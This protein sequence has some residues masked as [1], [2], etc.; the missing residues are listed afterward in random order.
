MT[1]VLYSSTGIPAMQN[2]LYRN[3]ADALSAPCAD[4]ELRRHE[5]GYVF[6]SKFNP[7]LTTYDESYHNDQGYSARFRQHLEMV[8]ALCKKYLTKNE[9]LI[10]DVGCGPSAMTIPMKAEVR[11]FA[12]SSLD[13]IPTIKAIF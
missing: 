13:Q 7:T 6:N 9:C 8:Y 1:E 12:N 10:V 5:T 4:I 3:Q 2:R 11:I